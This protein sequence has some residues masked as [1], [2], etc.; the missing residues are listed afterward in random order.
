MELHRPNAWR[1][2][3]PGGT[4]RLHSARSVEDVQAFV[5]SHDQ[6][7]VLGTRH[8]FNDI[9]D[10]THELL[11][12]REMNQVVALDPAARTVTIEAGMSYG[13]LCPLLDQK[14]FALHN[15]RRCRTSPSPVRPPRRH[16]DPA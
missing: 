16:T 3:R 1:A 13:Q 8:C 12:V 11:S 7:K 2:A 9:A 4:G 6:L 10:S 14:G 15:S 5:R